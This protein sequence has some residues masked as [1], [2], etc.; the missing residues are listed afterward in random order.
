MKLSKIILENR[1]YVVRE[2]LDLSES[3]IKK[4]SKAISN[5]L[6]EYLD[7]DNKTFLDQ[8]VNAAISDL[9]LNEDN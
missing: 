7:I 4:L 5:K 1:K 2:Q 8:T 6:Q 3:D 9:L